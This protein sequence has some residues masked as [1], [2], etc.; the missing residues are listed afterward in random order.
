MKHT[1]L[2]IFLF[3]HCLGFGQNI[4]VN[5]NFETGT[6]D[7]WGGYTNQ[8]LI[9]DI[10]N[11]FCGNNN[12]GDSSTFQVFTVVP[13]TVY[14]VSFDYRWVSGT[15]AYNMTAKVK[16]GASGGSDLGAF[17]LNTTPDTWELYDI[18]KDPNEKNNLYGINEKKF[19]ELQKHYFQFI[20]K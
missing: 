16:N 17:V 5:G 18:K 10:T 8:V 7:N 11:S 3:I 14:H 9:D 1:I 13:E 19:N 20:K 12:N 2:S 4:L 6:L 15:A